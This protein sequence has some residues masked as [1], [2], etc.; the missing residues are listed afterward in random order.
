[1]VRWCR[2]ST[3]ARARVT[4]LRGGS[5]ATPAA[6]GVA[7]SDV[8]RN[9]FLCELRGRKEPCGPAWRRR[10]VFCLATHLHGASSHIHMQHNTPSCVCVP[11][12]PTLVSLAL[13]PPRPCPASATGTRSRVAR[14]R[15]EYP[16]QLDYGGD[17]DLREI[18]NSVLWRDE[19][20]CCGCPMS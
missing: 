12:T 4:Q 13:C 17:V 11:H 18:E 3:E 16:S 1:M 14:V 20:P 19:H 15:A 9:P 10:E 8:K 5:I 2:P 6:S 7:P